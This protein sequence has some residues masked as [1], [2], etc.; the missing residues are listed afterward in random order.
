MLQKE[1]LVTKIGADTAD[2]EPLQVC[3]ALGLASPDLGSLTSLV[4]CKLNGLGLPAVLDRVL[5]ELEHW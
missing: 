1:Y 4:R 2:N 5:S 3:G